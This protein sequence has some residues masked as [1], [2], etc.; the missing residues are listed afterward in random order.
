[1]P[2]PDGSLRLAEPL[3]GMFF[4]ELF[5]ERLPLVELRR[6]R[7][8]AA[9][10]R[11]NGIPRTVQGTGRPGLRGGRRS[12]VV[13]RYTNW[14]SVLFAQRGTLLAHGQGL[15]RRH[16]RLL[17]AW[18]RL[19]GRDG[20]CQD[21]SF[22]LNTMIANAASHRPNW[23]AWDLRAM[24]WPPTLNAALRAAFRKMAAHRRRLSPCWAEPPSSSR[25]SWRQP[26]EDEVSRIPE[27]QGQ[28]EAV[29]RDPGRAIRHRRA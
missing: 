12:A 22:T 4:I 8:P 28:V 13:L 5:L 7:G 20:V 1:M 19:A 24:G 10:P 27:L 9:L 3:G 16:G 6:R 26:L 2:N 17:E 15:G 23:T 14:L 29:I 25:V 18:L 11:F 21:D